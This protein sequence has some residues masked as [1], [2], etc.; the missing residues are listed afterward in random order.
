MKYVEAGRK[1][2]NNPSGPGEEFPDYS[3]NPGQWFSADQ[4][5]EVFCVIE[6]RQSLQAT[7]WD[8]QAHQFLADGIKKGVLQPGKI[9]K[10]G[11]VVYGLMHPDQVHSPIRSGSEHDGVTME[12]GD[13]QL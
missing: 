9:F 4:S 7:E 5:D 2:N 3:G 6:V 13:S 8:I 11:L 12:R 10:F 1:I